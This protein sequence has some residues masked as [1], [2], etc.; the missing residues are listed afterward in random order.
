MVRG[1]NQATVTFSGPV[2]D[3]SARDFSGSEKSAVVAMTEGSREF[4]G[5][6]KDGKE[7]GGRSARDVVPGHQVSRP[8]E[9]CSVSPAGY[10][11]GRAGASGIAYGIKTRQTTVW[12]CYQQH[13]DIFA[14]DSPEYAD[15]VDA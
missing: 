10:T 12:S 1:A 13:H 7:I 14:T 8:L 11:P 5:T 4:R 6:A 3:R 15:T 2:P 9:S